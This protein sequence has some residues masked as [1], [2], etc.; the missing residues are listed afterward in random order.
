MSKKLDEQ[1]AKKWVKKF[2]E[3]K[4]DVISSAMVPR[5]VI[6]DILKQSNNGGIRIYNAYNENDSVDGKLG[7]TM[8]VLGT[9]SN[10]ENQLTSENT[11]YSIYDDN[12][13]CPPS[14]PSNDL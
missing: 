11:S 12:D 7:Y 2:K 14:C 9:Y 6:E 4:S 5:S 10:G 3:K 1:K 8:I 13:T